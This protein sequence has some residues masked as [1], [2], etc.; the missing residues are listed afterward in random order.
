[1]ILCDVRNVGYQVTEQERQ[2]LER[3]LQTLLWEGYQADLLNVEEQEPEERWLI[4]LNK[5]TD[6][7]QLICH[8]DK[9]TVISLDR[10]GAIVDHLSL[11][12]ADLLVDGLILHEEGNQKEQQKPKG[13]EIE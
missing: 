6:L 4:E 12:D 3:D 10:Q 13:L 2:L 9:H 5:N 7:I 11:E 8:K 1:M